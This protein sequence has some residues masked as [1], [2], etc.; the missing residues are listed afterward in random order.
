MR[1]LLLTL[2]LGIV[3]SFSYTSTAGIA[4]QRSCPSCEISDFT[5]KDVLNYLV[6]KGAMMTDAKDGVYLC[7][8]VSCIELKDNSNRTWT[9]AFVSTRPTLPVEYW[10]QRK[11]NIRLKNTKICAKKL[12][13]HY[14][15]QWC[16]DNNYKTAM[17]LYTT[18]GQK[19][20]DSIDR[21]VE[22]ERDRL[23]KKLARRKKV[24]MCIELIEEWQDKNRFFRGERPDCSTSEWSY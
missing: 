24:L 17:D 14:D 11:E 6:R 4:H 16:K 15:Y 21:Q 3:A 1:I 8:N 12:K 19:E 10:S 18:L 2:A 5:D 23:I 9:T 13:F 7:L 22:E 20:Q